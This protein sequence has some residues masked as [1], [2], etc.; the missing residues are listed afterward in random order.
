MTGHFKT[1]ARQWGRSGLG[2]LICGSLLC[3]I[4]GWISIEGK[5]FRYEAEAPYPILTVVGLYFAAS[6]LALAA[7]VLARKATI[8]KRQFLFCVLKQ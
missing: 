8:S 6:V 4:F 7:M 2:V 3:C 1:Q 5:Q